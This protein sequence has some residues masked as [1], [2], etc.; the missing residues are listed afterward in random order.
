MKIKP[1]EETH[2]DGI[3]SLENDCF[4]ETDG[5]MKGDIG[6]K[7]NEDGRIWVCINGVSFIRF[8]PYGSYCTVGGKL[9]P[10]KGVGCRPYDK[11]IQ[12]Y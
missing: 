11:K 2:I 6:I 12:G 1:Y 5:M 4:K 3:I 9:M 7:I 10:Q 8:K